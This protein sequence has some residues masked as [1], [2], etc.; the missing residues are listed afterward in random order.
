MLTL[1]NDDGLSSV[2]TAGLGKGTV[3]ESGTSALIHC[4]VSA[5]PFEQ[6][7]NKPQMGLLIQKCV[8]GTEMGQA[9][10]GFF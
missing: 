7:T 3:A 5:F 1:R 6:V 8:V 10:G 9:H 4:P 2:S